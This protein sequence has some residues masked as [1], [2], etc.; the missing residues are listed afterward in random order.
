MQ[1]RAERAAMTAKVPVV[2]SVEAPKPAEPPSAAPTP[3][4]ALKQAK[5]TIKDAGDKHKAA[6]ELVEKMLDAPNAATDPAK[7]AAP[8]VVVFESPSPAVEVAK[9]TRDFVAMQLGSDGEF[10][11]PASSPRPSLGFVRWIKAAKI[12]GVRLTERPRVLIG[13]NGF[14]F[15]D[16]VDL[17][18]GIVLEGYNAETRA[19]RF[20]EPSGAVIE[21]RI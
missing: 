8:Q 5:D 9:P 19:L 6:Y 16:V 7:K 17:S 20:K 18:L 4:T 10:V 11:V 13:A 21:R 3:F 2:A 1:M 15:G 12:G 14:T